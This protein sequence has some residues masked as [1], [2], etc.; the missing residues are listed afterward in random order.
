ML[1]KC[2]TVSNRFQISNQIEIDDSVIMSVSDRLNTLKDNFNS[3]FSN[4]IENYRQTK[5][6]SN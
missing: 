5:W 2:S 3:Y 6:I 4:E 1:K